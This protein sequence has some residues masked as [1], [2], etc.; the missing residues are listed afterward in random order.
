MKVNAIEV[1]VSGQK[2]GLL[3]QENDNYVFTYSPDIPEDRFV[4]L[5]M[6]VRNASYTYPT[7][8]PVFDMSQPEGALKSALQAEFQKTL[9]MDPMGFLAL[10]G[11]QRIGRVQYQARPPVVLPKASVADSKTVEALIEEDD[12]ATLFHELVTRYGDKSGVAGV[13]PKVLANL[14]GQDDHGVDH[15]ARQ[16]I[17]TSGQDYPYLA[18]NE[19][20]CLSVAKSAGL[21]VPEWKVLG[22]GQVIVVDRFDFDPESEGYLGFE[23]F[24]SLMGVGADEKYNSHIERVVKGVAPYLSPATRRGELQKLFELFVLNNLLRNG[25]AHLKNYGVLY[26]DIDNVQLAP[27]YDIVTTTAYIQSDLPAML[28]G[29]RKAWAD[30]KALVTLGVRSMQVTKAGADETINRISA[31][32]ETVAPSI[33]SQIKANLGFADI[34][35]RMLSQWNDGIKSLDAKKDAAKQ[36]IHTA[37]DDLLVE[38]APAPSA[39]RNK[40]H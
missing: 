3:T 10:T 28:V 31:A 21:S 24:A 18:L 32:I 25:D 12:V 7:L 27:A 40:P 35:N 39:R 16:I 1:L 30:R 26:R 17:K 33:V 23:E 14:L 29:G 19:S 38:S 5:T 13:Q 34:G 37:I 6:P 11:R 4:S 15:E 22:D 2:V 36:Q 20:L 9:D 8:H